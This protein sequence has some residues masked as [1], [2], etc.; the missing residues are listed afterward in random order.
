MINIDALGPTGP[1]RS[2]APKPIVALDGTQVGELSEVPALYV[3]RTLAA[4]R[5]ATMPS[6]EERFTMMEKAADIFA[7]DTEDYITTVCRV[8][9]SPRTAVEDAVA[10]VEAVL[11]SQRDTMEFAMP[12]GAVAE[13]ADPATVDGS[14]VWIRKG[15]IFAV[16]AAGNTPAVHGLWPEALAMGYKVVVRPSAREPFTAFRLI[17]ALR[18]A[19]FAPDVV[20]L[21]P[22]DYAAADVIIAETDYAIVYGGQEVVDKYGT[23]NRVLTQG[24]GRSKIL[25]TKDTDWRAAVDVI[26]GSVSH[27]G[28]TACT[29]ATAVLVEGDPEPLARA[30]AEKLGEIPSHTPEDPQALLP[31]QPVETA[32]AMDNYLHSAAGDAQPLLGGDTVVDELPSGGA[33]LRPAVHLVDSATAPQLNVELGFPCVWVGPWSP[34]DGV[35]PLRDSLVLTAMTERGELIGELL[36]EPTITNIYVGAHPTTW[37][38]PGIPHDGYL[39]EFL[40]R[41]KAMI[42]SVNVS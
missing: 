5:A 22:T 17:S 27:L 20:T 9:G 12:K 18:E 33:V 37:I 35:A 32:R 16:H 19:G 10:W 6:A 39:G 14:A 25:V 4:M 24:P 8:S 41:T 34:A 7:A 31:V 3:R 21:L 29:C 40:M 30:L 1:Y 26:A 23:S 38:R 13:W 2:R 36:A 15:D 11:R 28:G 42:R